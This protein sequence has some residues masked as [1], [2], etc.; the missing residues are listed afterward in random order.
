MVKLGTSLL[1]AAGAE[2]LRCARSAS[3]YRN[4]YESG[5]FYVAKVKENGRLVALKGSRSLHPHQAAAHVV[6]WYAARFGDGWP[7]ALADR[8]R[9]YWR[10]RHSERWGGWV[11]TVWADGRAQVARHKD[12]RGRLTDRPM[13]FP[14]RAA[15]VTFAEE[16][17]R[18]RAE[19]G[20]DFAA[21]RCG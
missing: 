20:C 3:G 14:T 21:W 11:L 17:M 9:C 1:P 8:K 5:R 12:D 10:V 18:R 7:F 2:R 13:V 16:D 4:V 6:A 15:A 19:L